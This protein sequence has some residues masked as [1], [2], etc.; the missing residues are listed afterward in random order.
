MRKPLSI[1]AVVTCITLLAGSLSLAGLRGRDLPSRYLPE[2][3]DG[4][5][6][7]VV[8][9]VDGR[10]WSTWAYRNGGEYDIAVAYRHDDG[11]W[12]E[13]L[14]IGVDDGRNQAE[15]V[16]TADLNGSLYLAWAERAPD[17]IM[18]SWLQAG[19]RTW[20]TPESL[21]APGVLAAAPEL[22]V[23]GD[24]LVVAFHAGRGTA[25][26]EVPLVDPLMGT[27]IFNDGPDPIDV[28]PPD[29]N[30]DEEDDGSAKS[31]YPVADASQTGDT[32]TWQGPTGN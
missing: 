22:K 20:S 15:P 30:E 10:E 21:T 13:P 6:D 17:R 24:H 16:I 3:M 19:S 23:V 12:S 4:R 18:I 29:E 11:Q 8:N 9:P 27:T 14:L 5:L 28:A 31:K 32:T 2:S 7:L 26:L 1:I 25:I